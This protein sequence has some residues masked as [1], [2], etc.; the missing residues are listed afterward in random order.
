MPKIKTAPAHKKPY[1]YLNPYEVYVY[2]DKKYALICDR[3]NKRLFANFQNIAAII[4][5]YDE[6]VKELL[7]NLACKPDWNDNKDINYNIIT[8]KTTIQKIREIC[9]NL[10]K[11]SGNDIYQK[12]KI[13][14]DKQVIAYIR[15]EPKFVYYKLLKDEQ[16]LRWEKDGEAARSHI[17]C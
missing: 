4:I 10:Y 3:G 5:N 12:A 8:S 6:N 7:F 1:W 11:L 2:Y 15:Q 13:L 14:A 9:D 16:G 17:I